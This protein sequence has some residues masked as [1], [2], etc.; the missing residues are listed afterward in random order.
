MKVAKIYE[1]PDQGNLRGGLLYDRWGNFDFFADVT[2]LTEKTAQ[3]VE[4]SVNVPSHERGSFMR[5][6][7]PSTVSA[8]SYERFYFGMPGKGALPGKTY[9]FVA[10][11]DDGTTLQKRDFTWTG[12]ASALA[13]FMLLQAER[14]TDIYGERGNLI[15]SVADASAP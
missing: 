6:P 14:D 8:H 12:T 4:K 13:G 9:T 10:F 11:E 3:S 2:G 5:D 15:V 1:I 7:N